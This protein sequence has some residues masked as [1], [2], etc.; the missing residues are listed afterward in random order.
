MRVL[1]YFIFIAVASFA[2][3]AQ[4]VVTQ[5]TNTT[6]PL[7]Y[8]GQVLQGGGSQT[9]LSETQRERVRNQV[10]NATRDRLPSSF[11]CGGTGWRR[12]VYLNMSDPLK[13]NK[14]FPHEEEKIYSF[15][16]ALSPILVFCCKIN[17]EYCSLRW[18]QW[19]IV[20]CVH[21][22]MQ[23]FAKCI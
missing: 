6:L 21:A 13:R 7:T 5:E 8:P 11:Y 22:L 3:L 1:V 12:V 15:S 14:S 4:P 20:L 19:D 17:N 10:K 16:S 2:V 9:C 23:S 18:H